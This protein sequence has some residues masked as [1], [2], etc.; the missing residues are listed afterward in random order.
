MVQL[1]WVESV[2]PHAVDLLPFYTCVKAK[3]ELLPRSAAAVAVA[4][5]HGTP[6]NFSPQESAQPIVRVISSA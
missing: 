6:S 4:A 3:G 2:K 5:F 1:S